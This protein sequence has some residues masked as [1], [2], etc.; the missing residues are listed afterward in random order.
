MLKFFISVNTL[1][2]LFFVIKNYVDIKL[3]FFVYESD[4]SISG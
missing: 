4:V 3:V 2:M 1:Y